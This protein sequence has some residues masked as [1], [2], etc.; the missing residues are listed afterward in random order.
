MFSGNVSAC[1]RAFPVSFILL[2]LP[3]DAS[4]SAYTDMFIYQEHGLDL[5]R[6]I[7]CCMCSQEG[8]RVSEV[9]SHRESRDCEP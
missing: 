9:L 7:S 3:S 6:C 8:Q 5:S 1:P 2:L 4:K